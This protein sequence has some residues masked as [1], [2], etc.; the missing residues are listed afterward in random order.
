MNSFPK[1]S[2]DK[3]FKKNL[4]H[5]SI[6]YNPSQLSVDSTSREFKNRT[7]YIIFKKD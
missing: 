7:N 5:K 2:A 1:T 3:L 6:S 4:E